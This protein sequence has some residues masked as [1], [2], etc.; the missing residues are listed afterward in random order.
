MFN[1]LNGSCSSDTTTALL[2]Q[3]AAGFGIDYIR[4][5]FNC[6][7]EQPVWSATTD[8]LDRS[9]FCGYKQV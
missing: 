8:A 9:L 7:Q 2:N 3:A 5:S 1:L 6:T 4:S